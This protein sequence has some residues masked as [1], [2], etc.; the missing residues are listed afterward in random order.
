MYGGFVKWEKGVRKDGSD[1]V[2]VQVAPA[3]HWPELEV[4]ILV[5][6]DNKKPV[7][8]TVG[9]RTSVQTSELLRH[10]A[11][12]IV[13]RRMKEMEEA[14][15]K[16][17][18]QTFGHLTMQVYL[19]TQQNVKI[20]AIIISNNVTFEFSSMHLSSPPPSCHFVHATHTIYISFV[21]TSVHVFSI[22][23]SSYLSPYRTATTPL[24]T[25]SPY[26]PSHTC[27][28]TG[29]QP[30]PCS[31]SG[32]LP[33]HILPQRYITSNHTIAHYV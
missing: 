25:P 21:H 7:S 2:A 19:L 30:V 15:L 28:P 27:P 6:S 9:M 14:I 10:R 33:T 20:N 3:E 16:K 8:S 4:L 12:V 5:V 13:P 31:L 18:F 11:D 22:H 17:D 32:H 1:S 24:C 29:Q 23:T 26:T